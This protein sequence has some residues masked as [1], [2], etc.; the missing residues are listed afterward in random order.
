MS[1][2]TKMSPNELLELVRTDLDPS[3]L[4]FAAEAL[5]R[6]QDPQA[7]EELRRLLK[8]ESPIVRE[9]AIYGACGQYAKLFRKK[10]N[11]MSENDPSEGVREA[12]YECLDKGMR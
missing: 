6:L 10:I 5:G 4:T 1:I 8:H 2:Y 12:A 9:G 7:I 11:E 3:K